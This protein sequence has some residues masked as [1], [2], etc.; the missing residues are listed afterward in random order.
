MTE[1]QQ[2][3][4]RIIAGSKQAPAGTYYP[5]LVVGI[6]G[7]GTRVL[8]N[9]KKRLV[10]TNACQIRLLGIDSDNS[11][12]Q[13]FADLPPLSDSELAILDYSVAVRALEQAAAGVPEAQHILEFLPDKYDG[14]TGLHQE[15]KEKIQTQMG[16]GQFRRAGKLLF[17]SNVNAGANLKARFDNL[18]KELTGLPPTVA[19]IGA[20]VQVEQGSRVYVVCSIAGGT[21]AGSLLDCLALVRK[22]FS[23]KF[24]V[25]TAVLILPGPLLDRI[26]FVPYTEAPQTRGNAVGVLRELQPFLLGG[27]DSHQFVFD[28]QTN[29]IL[30]TDSLVNDVFL[31]DHSTW[32]GRQAEDHLDLYRAVSNFLYALVGSGVGASLASGRINGRIGLE[33]KRESMVY[34]S[35]G[36]AAVEYPIE[37]LLEYSL[38]SDLHA[39]LDQWLSDKAD[40]QSVGTNVDNF[41]TSLGLGTLDALRATVLQDNTLGK[42]PQEWR[43]RVMRES[44]PGFFN[45]V[46]HQR[47]VLDTVLA[48]R[49]RVVADNAQRLIADTSKA[50]DAT[51]LGWIAAGWK[52]TTL[53]L[54]AIRKSLETLADQRS[55]EQKARQQELASLARKMAGKE[56]WINRIGLGLDRTARGEYL[57][58]TEKQMAMRIA[59]FLDPKVAQVLKQLLQRVEELEAKVANLKNSVSTF[60]VNNK[61]TLRSIEQSKPRSCFVQTALLPRDYPEWFR[62]QSITITACPPPTGFG[63]GELL[64]A[65]LTP[66]LDTWRQLIQQ[67]DIKAAAAGNEALRRAVEATNIAGEPL[68][69]LVPTAPHR[70]RMQPQKL[71]A[72]PFDEGDPFV[73]SSFTQVGAREVVSLPTGDKHRIVCVQTISGF[74]ATHWHGFDTAEASYH[75]NAWLYHTFPSLDGLPQLRPLEAGQWAALRDF[76]LG[77]AFELIAFRGANFYMNFVFYDPEKT[78]RYLLYKADADLTL[79]SAKLLEC[80]LVKRADKTQTRP[81]RRILLGNSLESAVDALG[82]ANLQ[83]F[84]QELMEVVEALIAT[85]GKMEV[86]KAIE[87][88]VERQLSQL[89]NTA[90]LGS[91]RRT[92][93]EQIRDALRE[94]ANQLA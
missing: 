25:V 43:R 64:E 18:K 36:A 89:I 39:W 47:D 49:E 27:V 60:S 69:E 85:N 78:Y 66:V 58:M 22:T 34:S 4:N 14:L 59:D 29:F 37:D 3:V 38:R 90:T 65:A 48:E 30:G 15:V 70:E 32:S 40:A 53:G 17:C 57:S 81:D 68:I 24:D 2:F 93:L 10:E 79:G 91:K 56:K 19:Q 80:G 83:S 5:T 1:I 8:R 54:E 94:Y 77:L 51:V 7:M 9:L 75:Q 21:G 71:V 35:F 92:I 45:A 28:S 41:M 86:K 50:L 55:H 63:L 52:A 84:R 16:A 11:E 82:R 67:M 88:Y 23:S 87:D 26:L 72:G 12:N 42:L 20:G 61:N 6:G 76:G 73:A 31:V 33:H 74:G 62:R 46:W 13:K 44:D